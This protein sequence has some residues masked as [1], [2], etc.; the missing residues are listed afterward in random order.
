MA[1][2]PG[3]TLPT[4][5]FF[6][7]RATNRTVRETLGGTDQVDLWRL[8]LRASSFSASLSGLAKKTNADVYLLNAKG[9]A[10]AASRR[11]GNRNENFSRN[12]ASGTYY[13]AVVLGQ[14][15]ASTR[16]SLTL[17]A[18]T[19]TDFLSNTFEAAPALDFDAA[20]TSF[21]EFVGKGDPTDFIQFR[22][23]A[24]GNMALK[25][26]NLNADV[27]L[28]L[29]DRNRTLIGSSTNAK[30][31][32]ET[33]TQRLIDYG[34][35]YYIRI[36]QGAGKEGFYNFSYTFTP[37]TPTTTASG[38]QYVDLVA[39]A[40]ARPAAGQKVIV[41]YTGTLEN[42][43]KFDSSRDRNQPFEFTLG[44][45]RVIP[46]WEEGISSMQVGGRRQLIIPANLAYGAGGVPGSIPPNATL[47]F[48]V[49]LV[50]V[51]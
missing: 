44:A 46:G 32:N 35:T 12:L 38:L 45:G 33:I 1:R 21:N 13:V 49:E 31:A 17:S 19:P 24:P 9:E 43:M 11:S 40:G 7:T 28:E 34:S 20:Q 50:A 29:Y 22:L 5:K 6:R 41:Q 25:L 42:G 2:D 36:G 37:D 30:T 4:A 16:Y 39:G 51:A 14:G 10:I 3:N 15:S 47:I 27:N 23:P 26:Q 18:P 48:D 8:K